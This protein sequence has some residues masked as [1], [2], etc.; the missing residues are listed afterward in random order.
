MWPDLVLFRIVSSKPML[1]LQILS[2]VFHLCLCSSSSTP[3]CL[4]LVMERPC[5]RLCPVVHSYYMSKPC[6]SSFSDLLY[7]RYSVTTLS[8]D[9]ITNPISSCPLPRY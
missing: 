3:C 6:Q 1:C 2:H 8:N 9:F 4:H 5:C 7:Q